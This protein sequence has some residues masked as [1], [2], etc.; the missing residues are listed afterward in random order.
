MVGKIGRR[1]QKRANTALAS[2]D[3][4]SLVRL[5]ERPTPT[6]L[7]KELDRLRL[8]ALANPG[9]VELNL[10]IAQLKVR[11]ARKHDPKAHVHFVQG[12]TPDS[13]RHKH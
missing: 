3:D 7:R 10:N 6:Q 13:N 12:G 5:P 4:Q 11:I 8:L 2:L 1:A 9:N